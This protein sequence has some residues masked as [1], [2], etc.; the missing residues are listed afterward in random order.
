MREWWSKLRG[1]FGRERLN[2]DLREEAEAHLQMEVEANLERGMTPEAALAKARG[3][4]GNRTLIHESGREAWI[5]RS[6]EAFF[7]DL[8]YAARSLRQQP[9]FTAVVVLT[10]AV[11]IGANT[12]IYS[13]VDATML[14]P[15]PFREPDRLMRVSL[16]IPADPAQQRPGQDDMIW[17]YPKYE[18][19]RDSQD[20]FESTAVYRA[21]TFNLT[22]DGDPERL[23]GEEV[24]ASYFPMLGVDA[25]VG[26]TFL[27]E[28]DAVPG[29][30]RVALLSFGLW[31][32]RFGGDPRIAGQTI[33]LDTGTFT[34]VGVMPQGF[35]G[36][37]GPAD[38]WVP[39]H[40][41]S[42]RSLS[43][44]LAH[45]W[46]QVAR[47]QPGVSEQQAREVV[48]RLG[49]VVDKAYP[50]GALSAAS[51]SATAR[52]LNDVRLD[53]AIGRSVLVLFG[54]VGFM[55]LI[56]CVNV[57]SLL[58][59][60]GSS[61]R[62]EI[63]I[64]CAVGAG[65]GRV[66]RQLMTESLLLAGLGA[67][68]SL[69]LG[70]AGVQALR[71]LYDPMAGT[72]LLGP[73]SG[74]TLLGLASIHMDARTLG[75]TAAV[76]LGTGLL[77]GLAPAWQSAR[78]DVTD[79]LKKGGE[80]APGRRFLGGR[81]VL[82]VA[83]I[84]LA[85][86]LLAGAGLTLRSFGKLIATPVGVDASHVLTARVSLPVAPGL[87]QRAANVFGEWEPRVAE[88]P[89]VVSAGLADCAPLSGL[90][91]ALGVQLKGPPFDVADTQAYVGFHRVSAG[92]FRTMKI[93]L[94][95]GRTFVETDRAGATPVIVVSE[96]AA[97][98]LWPGEDALGKI[99]NFGQVI[100]VA[101]DVRYG[102]MDEPLKPEVYAS[103]QQSAAPGMLLFVRTEGDPVALTAAVRE[104]VRQLD[105][106]LPVYEIKTMEARLGEAIGRARLSAILL[107]LFGGAALLLAAVGI[108][109]VLSYAVRQRTREIGIRMALGARAEDM[110]WLVVRRTAALALTGLAIGL[111][112]ALAATRVL[113][114]LLY[115]VTPGDP[116]TYVVTSA[117]LLGVALLAGYLP[118]RRASAV[119]PVKTLRVE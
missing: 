9:G 83:E 50:L 14:R 110:R 82:V 1:V 51:W 34:V 69:A 27:P 73:Q 87:A 49:A 103:Y 91:S 57:A 3:E 106:A 10:L 12:A 53:P 75:F 68:A 101:G 21:A 37:S 79:A 114:T 104:Q 11:G 38:L 18:L 20:V 39:A 86:V 35:Q 98:E 45:S 2:E 72:A 107:G 8:R 65:R 13:V 19:F 36:L 105:A 48:A 64:R 66:V 55:L 119:D 31:Q 32:R 43:Q 58:L 62:R 41:G 6:V 76:A 42:A 33:R 67:A 118:A 60:R 85:V 24:S 28:E 44:P 109:G 100:G 81:S 74:L 96:T 102:A 94:L 17:S 40:S 108:Y 15:L 84:A 46:Q 115:E 5:F 52:S 113:T 59:A 23:R 93:P 92:Y 54:A 111:A 47:L 88:L 112:G 29:R 70:Y 56:A 95:R 4:F 89:G 63:A 71:S 77:F 7:Q 30:D 97:R 22:G 99:T 116:A 61:R 90:C 80:P 78:A 26:R 25:A 16:V 117:V